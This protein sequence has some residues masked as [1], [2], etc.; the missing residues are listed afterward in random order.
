MGKKQAKHL[1][2]KACHIG[3]RFEAE[4]KELRELRA[5][6]SRSF[7]ESNTINRPVSFVFESCPSHWG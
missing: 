1:V 2:L 6:I 7:N 3:L 5:K 4:L